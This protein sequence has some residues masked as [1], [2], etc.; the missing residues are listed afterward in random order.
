M[1]RN[2]CA[3]LGQTNDRVVCGLKIGELLAQHV[4]QPRNIRQG[5]IVGRGERLSSSKSE[6]EEK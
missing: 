6:A 4:L 3:E 1:I 2:S 5:E